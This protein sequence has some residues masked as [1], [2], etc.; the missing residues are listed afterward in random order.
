MGKGNKGFGNE[1]DIGSA[2]RG[3]EKGLP[4]GGVVAIFGA[5]EGMV[6]GA[7]VESLGQKFVGGSFC[8]A[9]ALCDAWGFAE[10]APDDRESGGLAVGVGKVDGFADGSQRVVGHERS[11]HAN[12]NA[13]GAGRVGQA[14]S[15]AQGYA[16]VVGGKRADESEFG[17]GFGMFGEEGFESWK[18][19]VRDG[20]AEQILGFL[21]GLC[22][23]G[24]FGI[25]V[26]SARKGS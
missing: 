26:V 25:L 16:G 12:A 22:A 1:K 7:V 3:F 10:S 5:G 14:G 15:E 19:M 4:G 13:F 11:G 2:L 6:L 8:G 9:K 21:S 17:G 24:L 18:V 23:G 20:A